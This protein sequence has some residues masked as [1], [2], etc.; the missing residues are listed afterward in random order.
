MPQKPTIERKC[1]ECGEPFFAKPYDV[2]RGISRFCSRNCASKW[3]FRDK[4]LPSGKGKD[5]PNWKG[6]VIRSSRGYFYVLLS[7][8]PLAGKNGYV[9]R[10]N[11]VAEETLGRFLL[12]GEV[13]HHKNGNKED[14]STENLQVLL[15][16]AHSRLHGK[17]S[18]K[19][20]KERKPDSPSNK[21]YDW[22]SDDELL[23]MRE[24]LTLRAIAE[25]VGC[26]HKV[27]DRRIKRI[28]R[29]RA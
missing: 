2:K 23:S 20:P 12:P 9:K 28:R 6:G 13:V 4:P 26:N 18:G 17:A 3:R 22:P 7:E 10:A 21:R 14:D 19:K 25:L 24:H 5:N 15:N 16:D 11:L 27:V 29:G 8:H 1:A